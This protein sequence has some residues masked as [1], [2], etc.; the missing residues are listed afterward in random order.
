MSA[1]DVVDGARSQQRIAGKV[2]AFDRE[3]ADPANGRSMEGGIL[4]HTPWGELACSLAGKT[5]YERVRK[6]DESHTAPGAET[7]AELFGGEPCIILLDELSV[8]LRKARNLHGN[9]A[10]EQLSAF[11]TSLF[12]AVREEG[13]VDTTQARAELNDRIKSIFVGVTGSIFE[14]VPFPATPGEV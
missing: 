3:N 12:K 7:L 8:Y 11:L 10:G 13:N 1:Y 5:G 9:A 2:T 6:S 14:T 4:A